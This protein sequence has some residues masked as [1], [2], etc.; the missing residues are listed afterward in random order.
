MIETLQALNERRP[1]DPF[2][3]SMSNGRQFEVR[4]PNTLAIGKQ[5]ANLIDPDSD[6]WHYIRISQIASAD[7]APALDR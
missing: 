1:F 4:Y 3:I 6:R 5:L 2:T 7:H